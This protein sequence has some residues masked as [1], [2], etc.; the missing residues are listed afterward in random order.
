MGYADLEDNYLYL[1]AEGFG[2][3]DFLNHH[4]EAGSFQTRT[5]CQKE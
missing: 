3:V 1:Q 5:N 2:D 4:P